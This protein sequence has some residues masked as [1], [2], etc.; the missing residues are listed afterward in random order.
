MKIILILL[1]L[2]H[3]V[4]S[5]IE[6]RR[7]IKTVMLD[8]KQKKI[9]IILQWIIPFLWFILINSLLKTT[10]GSFEVPVKNDVSS[11]NYY[12]SGKGNPMS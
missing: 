8:K 12:E 10:P 9:N 1:L 5:L 11:N 6:T 4:L 3:I 7:I 2:A